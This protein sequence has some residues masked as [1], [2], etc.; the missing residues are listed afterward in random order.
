MEPNYPKGF[1]I[2]GPHKG[3]VKGS[4]YR[5]EHQAIVEGKLEGNPLNPWTQE[6][7]KTVFRFILVHLNSDE[8]NVWK[9]DQGYESIRFLRVVLR[10]IR[11]IFEIMV[12][13]SRI[14]H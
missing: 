7:S 8:M 10:P 13:N 9:T 3:Y 11:F 2:K 4:P 1:T 12:G 14:R 5:L 6:H